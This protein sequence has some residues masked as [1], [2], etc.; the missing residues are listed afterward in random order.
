VFIWTGDTTIVLAGVNFGADDTPYGD[1]IFSSFGAIFHTSY[2]NLF[3]QVQVWD[4]PLTGSIAGPLEAPPEE[5]CTWSATNAS[6]GV[7]PY[8]YQWSG[9]LSGTNI[10]VTGT[11]QAPG[12]WLYLTITDAASNHLYDQIYIPVDEGLEGCEY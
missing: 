9:A 10:N 2:D 3:P 11:I 12:E 5:S 6:G 8:S 4:A 7:W 1:G